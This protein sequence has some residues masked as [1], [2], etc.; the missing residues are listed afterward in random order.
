MAVGSWTCP[1]TDSNMVVSKNL[2]SLFGSPCSDDH[3]M[4]GSILGPLIVGNSHIWHP[5]SSFRPRLKFL[6]SS[7]RRAASRRR[8]GHRHAQHGTAQNPELPMRIALAQLGTFAVTC[9]SIRAKC[10]TLGSFIA[11]LPVRRLRYFRSA[12]AVCNS[13]SW[14]HVRLW[15]RLLATTICHSYH[16]HKKT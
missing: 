7:G 4:L 8:R 9:R 1:L 16:V 15:C 6:K 2:G 5:G 11:L 10:E 3:S 13:P 12:T 14:K